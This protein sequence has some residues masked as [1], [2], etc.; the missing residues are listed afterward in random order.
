MESP[1]LNPTDVLQRDAV[2]ESS[3][4]PYPGATVWKR[5]RTLC[6]AP[7]LLVM[8]QD[9][10]FVRHWE[11]RVL[12]P[13]FELLAVG[14]CVGAFAGALAR[15]KLSGVA[16][17]VCAGLGLAL[18]VLFAWAFLG[19]MFMDPGFLPFDWVRTQRTRYSYEEQLSGLAIQEKQFEYAEQN[20]P[21]S[22]VFSH[23]AG[24]F[25]VRGDHIC[26]WVSNWV[27]KRNHKQFLL[28]NFWGTLMCM[29]FGCVTV[30]SLSPKA[31]FLRFF[32]EL[33]AVCTEASFGL[34]M[35]CMLIGS[36][37]NLSKNRTTLMDIK[38]EE[39]TD[40]G[41][42]NN[43]KEVCGEGPLWSWLIPTPA[44]GDQL[45]L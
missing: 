5:V 39:S 19:T 15:G 40:L 13:V 18:L 6:G 10:L 9:R 44:F 41:C 12:A 8:P 33:L 42:C 34:T 16:I 26:M 3:A 7:V 43:F 29:L 1:I 37:F 21:P 45:N 20:R 30:L 2:E 17:V 11:V 27:G 36:L 25:V 22:S 38:D 23:S 32:L 35:L 4:V 24:R 28:M 31:S 14:L